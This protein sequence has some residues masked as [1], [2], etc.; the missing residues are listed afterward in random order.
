MSAGAGIGS[1]TDPSAGGVDFF[2]RSVALFAA[3]RARFAFW[4][5]A[6]GFAGKIKNNFY[7]NTAPFVDAGRRDPCEF[8]VRPLNDPRRVL[9][10][11]GRCRCPA[12]ADQTNGPL[13]AVRF[14]FDRISLLLRLARQQ[15]PRA[16]SIVIC[17]KRTR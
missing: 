6:T 1:T 17:L 11:A 10:L 16:A 4:P 15:I 3:L 9:H 13:V 12:G 7:K 5:A 2:L 14:T 8:P